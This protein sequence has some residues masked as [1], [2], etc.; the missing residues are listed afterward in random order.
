[1]RVDKYAYLYVCIDTLD[2][3]THAQTN[4]HIY[5]DVCVCVRVFVRVRVCVHMYIA[6]DLVEWSHCEAGRSGQEVREEV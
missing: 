2:H 5:I 3:H 6:V 4:L 1:M